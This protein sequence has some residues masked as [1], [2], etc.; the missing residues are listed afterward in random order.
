MLEGSDFNFIDKMF[1]FFRPSTGVMC[2]SGKEP[3]SKMYFTEY[4]GL[5]RCLQ[6]IKKAQSWSD[7]EFN[8]HH[9]AKSLKTLQRRGF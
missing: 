4:F 2:G 1:P 3:E 9:T 8:L 6:K 7:D 5:S